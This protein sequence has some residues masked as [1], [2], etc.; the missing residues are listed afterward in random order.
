V[1]FFDWQAASRIEFDDGTVL[2][3]C[4]QCRQIYSERNP[5]QEPPCQSCFVCLM[6]ENRDASKIYIES[7]GQVITGGLGQILDI[8]ILAVTKLMDLYGIK[9]QIETLRKVRKAFYHFLPRTK[10]TD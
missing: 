1:Q 2:T 8:N 6:E 9:N 3:Q 5:P 4:D 7:R 10:E